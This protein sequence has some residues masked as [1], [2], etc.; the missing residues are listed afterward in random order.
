MDP[1]GFS[2]ENFD[3]SGQWRAT[4]AG[5]AVDASG[6]ITGTDVDGT[7]MDLEG[8]AKL[9]A[10]SDMARRCFASQWL[11]YSLAKSLTSDEAAT[12]ADLVDAFTN[13]EATVRDLI[14]GVVASD[15][16]V[17]RSPMEQD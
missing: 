10:D 16:F 7:F 3:A 8:M 12:L 4:D 14:V 5:A 11:E 15:A 13:D 1:L 6:A 17:W 9:L 2:F